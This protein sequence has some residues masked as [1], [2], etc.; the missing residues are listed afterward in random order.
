MNQSSITC[1][2]AEAVHPCS[3]APNPFADGSIGHHLSFPAP[4]QPGKKSRAAILWGVASAVLS[5]LGFVALALFE[6]YNGM[7]TE[8]Q[9]DLKHF[10]EIQ[11]GF[12]KREYF[13]KFRE[14]CKEGFRELH[15]AKNARAQLEQEL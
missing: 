4:H 2:Q 1:R 5:G 11:S 3:A 9:K 15:E 14:K 6:Q 7:V 12:V 13:E 10:N 8:M